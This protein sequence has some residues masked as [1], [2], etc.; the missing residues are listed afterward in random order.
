MVVVVVLAMY[1]VRAERAVR[2]GA[3]TVIVPKEG[4][5]LFSTVGF[6]LVLFFRGLCYHFLLL[7]ALQYGQL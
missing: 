6:V 7:F 3:R 1:H 5:K 2:S 4:V